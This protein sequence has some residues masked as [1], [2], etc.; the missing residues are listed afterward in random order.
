MKKN[1]KVIKSSENSLIMSLKEGK[2]SD[3]LKIAQRGDASLQR[4]QEILLRLKKISKIYNS[5]LPE[6]YLNKKIKSTF[7]KN[8]FYFLQKNH[9]GSTLSK[10]KQKKK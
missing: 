9:H 1:F 2:S 10:L 4:E 3:I 7:L 8:K 6:I 5:Y